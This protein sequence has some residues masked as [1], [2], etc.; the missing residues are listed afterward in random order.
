LLLLL[1][2]LFV[3]VVSSQKP[4]AADIGMPDSPPPDLVA[5]RVGA[6]D[7]WARL[8]KTHEIM[9]VTKDKRVRV[10]GG[11]DWWRFEDTT[12]V[13]MQEMVDL[14]FVPPMPLERLSGAVTSPRS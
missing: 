12:A 11:E 5:R 13:V 10:V 1:L 8:K 2:L 9:D 14:S 4:S 7:D 3:A 6:N